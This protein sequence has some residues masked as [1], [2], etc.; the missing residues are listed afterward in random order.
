M[1]SV[2]STYKLI[3]N[4]SDPE[5]EALKKE[6]GVGIQS[7]E[8]TKKNLA[9]IPDDDKKNVFQEFVLG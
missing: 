4:M 7:L 3:A 2:M 1:H 9:N 8:T 5:S 6:L